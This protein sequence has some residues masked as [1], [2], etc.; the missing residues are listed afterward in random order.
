MLGKMKGGKRKSEKTGEGK[1][2]EKAGEKGV[3]IEAMQGL[4]ALC[5]S[6]EEAEA[7]KGKGEEKEV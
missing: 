3:G 1:I 4:Q 7:G 6:D 2:E 5:P